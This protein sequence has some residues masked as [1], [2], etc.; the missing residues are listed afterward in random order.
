MGGIVAGI[1]V[2]AVAVLGFFNLRR[3]RTRPQYAAPPSSFVVEDDPF[4]FG[5]VL[6]PRRGSIK[7]LSSDGH[8]TS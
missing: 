1:A 7:G 8:H 5:G 3:R 4:V 2:V 6:H